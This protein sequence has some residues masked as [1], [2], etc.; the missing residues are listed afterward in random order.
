[1]SVATTL[2]SPAKAKEKRQYLVDFE[3]LSATNQDGYG[4]VCVGSET[5]VD[6]KESCFKK[7]TYAGM[8]VKPGATATATRCGTM[9]NGEVGVVCNGGNTKVRFNDSTMHHNGMFSLVGD[10][11]AVVDLHGPKTNITKYRTHVIMYSTVYHSIIVV[12]Q[13]KLK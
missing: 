6:V 7:C 13:K 1:M 8:L 10:D 5:N 12:F 3:Q 11:H 9:E 2:Q 4:L